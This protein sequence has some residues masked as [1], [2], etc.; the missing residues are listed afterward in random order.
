MRSIIAV[1]ISF[2]LPVTLLSQNGNF[3]FGHNSLLATGKWH[4]IKITTEGIYKISYADLR[5]L[6]FSDPSAIRVFGNNQGQLSYYNNDP[7]PDDLRE[8]AID[9]NKGTDG[10]FNEGDYVLFH[11]AA[12]HRW[13]YDKSN[14]KY[15]YSRHNY[16]DTSVYFI[17]EM[18]GGAL[19]VATHSMISEQPSYTTNAY[20]AL[21]LKEEETE[22]II[23]S[24]REWYQPVSPLKGVE[25]NPGFQGLIPG[26]PLRYRLRVVG[27]SGV[28]SMFRLS[29]T[30]ETHLSLMVPEVNMFNTTGTYARYGEAEGILPYKAS[31][32]Y[33]ITFFRN[34]E[35]L[36]LGWLDYLWLHGRAELAAGQNTT[37]FSDARS[38]GPGLINEYIIKGQSSGV[39]VWDVTDHERPVRIS[40]TF[41]G[42]FIRFRAAADSLR[43]FALFRN[44]DVPA[45]KITTTPLPN[46]NLHATPPCDMIIVVHPWFRKQ[47]ERLATIHFD[48]S[49]LISQ[50]V[51]PFEIYN[52]FSGG[53][54]DISAI[55]NYIR[56]VWKRHENSGR[57]LRY[58]LLFGDG[59]YQNKIL[60][61]ANPNFIPTW[62]TQNSNIVVS[63]FMSDDFYGLLGEG[64]G[65][66][67]GFLD[68]GIGRLPASDTLQAS[69][70]VNKSD[71]YLNGADPG[72]WRN[73]I[74][75]VADDEDGNL[76]MSDAES[77]ANLVTSVNPVINTDKIYLD[78]FRQVTSINGQT[79]P[80]VTK[81][82]NDRI[83]KGTL[84]FNYLGHG[85]ELGLAHERVVKTTDINSWKNISRL[86]LFITA[87]CEFSRYD[88]VEY[89]MITKD[90]IGKTSAGE[91]AL[92]NPS[93]GAIA[94][95][96]TTRVVFS[97]PNYILNRNIYQY[98][99][100]RDSDGNPPRLGDIIRLAKI[101][102]GSGNNKRNFSLLGDPALRLAY[103][104][105]ASV[106]TD[107][108]NGRHISHASD[109]IKALSE[110]TLSG[111]IEGTNG[112]LLDDFT[113]VLNTVVY[114]KPVSITTLANDGGQKMEFNLMNSVLFSG[115]TM[116]KNGRF[117]LKFIV[118]RDIDY[119]YGK[120]K[121]SYYTYDGERHAAGYNNEI[122]VG[123]FS[124]SV[125]TD[126]T[127]PAIRLFLNNTLFRAG[128]ISD[129]EPFLFA[130]L[131]D[132]SGINTTGAGIGHDITMW[133][134]GENNN[135]IVLNNWFET[136][137]DNF[138]EGTIRYPLGVLSP[139][140]NSITLKA[141]DNYNN[142]SQ[143]TLYF[144]VGDNIRF[145]IS[146]VINYPN[147]FTHTTRITAGHNRPD[148]DLHVEINIYDM[149]G[150]K[151]RMIRTTS[152]AGGYQIEPVEWDRRADNGSLVGGGTYVFRITVSTGN[153][154]IAT[155][156][157]RMI[158]L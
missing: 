50:I 123:G 13:R 115:K 134:N 66:A 125:R 130:T 149:S 64:E 11:A 158:I 119:N 101:N 143:E 75:F 27:R 55:R 97:A 77:L 93:G 148:D 71:L 89:N 33:E 60:P 103:P 102:S 43:R 39:T 20:D 108:I 145:V 54:A 65:E 57:P 94:L 140:Q 86:P 56:M 14:G 53:I 21:Y 4:T 35:P 8:I 132:S 34:G 44:A 122:I 112:N 136:G 51:T 63:S 110:I 12:T 87:T 30:G 120:G 84:I 155:G 137:F 7:F 1:V 38:I 144:I 10:I 152:P 59:S 146:D 6:G 156:S 80:E 104:W 79:Y 28:P 83:G 109:T 113:G 2:I 128:G 95:M 129:S 9:F 147:P 29:S 116:V 45:A 69:I 24:G 3:D 142:S 99:F 17:T 5:Q 92:L 141:W 32:V 62:Q 76:H 117:R 139:G 26:E 81:A 22:N 82:I 61:P 19:S 88:D 23:G 48:N 67:T 15:L 41:D 126:T 107:S 37:I 31:P 40:T 106:I 46:Q 36:A 85:N 73:I 49:G 78:A 111:H 118:P 157:G 124:N 135:S 121:I 133:L 98:A 153:T 72:P 74:T 25:I 68:I 127:G 16:S 138:M 42:T 96:T 100:G 91:M 151:I 70:L 90:Y 154:E 47:A 114:D 105:E 52:E 18:A 150:R 58:L 131:S